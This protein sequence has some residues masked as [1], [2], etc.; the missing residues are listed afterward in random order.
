[1]EEGEQRLCLVE[2]TLELTEKTPL[3]VQMQLMEKM[4][5]GEALAAEVVLGDKVAQSATNIP[6]LPSQ[7]EMEVMVELVVMEAEAAEVVWE[8]ASFLKALIQEREVREVR[9]VLE[10]EAE[11][12]EV[13]GILAKEIR[14]VM[15]QQEVMAEVEGVA[16]LLVGVSLAVE[17]LVAAALVALD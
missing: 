1:M 12:A 14:L 13:L 10:E 11:V 7:Q 17:V 9:E 8:G 2:P 16:V 4:E 5:G 15:A 6:L 3:Q